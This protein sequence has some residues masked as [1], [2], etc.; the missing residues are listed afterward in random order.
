MP[1]SI[2]LVQNSVRNLL[3]LEINVKTLCGTVVLL[4]ICALCKKAKNCENGGRN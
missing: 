3:F 1:F 2:K 4:E